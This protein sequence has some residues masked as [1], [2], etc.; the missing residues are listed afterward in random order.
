MLWP[1]SKRKICALDEPIPF[2]RLIRMV[3]RD[4]SVID[5]TEACLFLSQ[6][7]AVVNASDDF[8]SVADSKLLIAYLFRRE[9]A[10]RWSTAFNA[11]VWELDPYEI[12][13]IYKYT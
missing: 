5:Q 10:R 12:V 9:D 7:V 1:R 13:V 4:C 11:V 6:Y 3:E 2:Y 8:F